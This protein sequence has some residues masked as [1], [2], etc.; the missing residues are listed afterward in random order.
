[1]IAYVYFNERGEFA[2]A[3]A[4][5]LSA[6]AYP[7]WM[8]QDLSLRRRSVSDGT[9][10]VQIL[11]RAALQ[12]VTPEVGGSPQAKQAFGDGTNDVFYI[13][14]TVNAGDDIVAGSRLS[15][16]YPDSTIINPGS[17]LLIE[18]ADAITRL[19][20]LAI[21]DVQSGTPSAGEIATEASTEVNIRSLMQTFTFDV[22][23]DVSEA[24]TTL[25][26]RYSAAT[27]G[28]PAATANYVMAIVEGRG[29][30]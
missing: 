1:M 25:R 28:A 22:A 24:V 14:V 4:T 21:G 3:G 7:G 10:W 15:N 9:S 6:A 26:E 23:D 2:H 27:A 16:G 17:Q 8:E 30:A 20:L 11:E 29:N 5:K 19:D 12:S 13:R 18:A